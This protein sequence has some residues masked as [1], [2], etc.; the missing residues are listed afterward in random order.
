MPTWDNI[1]E[2]IQS[3]VSDIEKSLK[4]L[5]TATLSEVDKKA[6][7]K[8]IKERAETKKQEIEAKIKQLDWKQKERAETLLKTLND[9]IN[10]Q[11]SI[12]DSNADKSK[13]WTESKSWEAKSEKWTTTADKWAAEWNWTTDWEKKWFFWKIWDG[14]SNMWSDV[15]SRDKWKEQPWKNFLYFGWTLLTWYAVYRWAKSLRNRVTWKKK[16]DK[17]KDKESEDKTE[18]ESSSREDNT[19]EEKSFWDKPIWKFIKWAWAVLWVWT[20]VYYLAH[21]LYTKNWWMKDL[22]DWERGKKL[23]FDDALKY[24][25]WAVANQDNKEGMWYGLDLKYH[26][27]TSEI[28]AYGEKIKIDKDKR[29]IDWLNI[30]FKKYENMICTAIVI[31]YLKKTYSWKCANNDP[32]HFNGNWQWDI[33]VN[34]WWWEEALDWTWNQGRIL[35]V[36]AAWIAWIL[37]WIFGWPQA[38]L[39]VGGVWWVAWYAIGS[40]IDHNNIMNDVMPELDNEYW[41]KVLSW[42]L[43]NM[44]CREARNQTKE[45]IS[46]S[47]IKDKVR[48]FVRQIQKD[49]P[50]LPAIWWRMQFDAIPDSTDK[51]KYTIKA[52]GREIKAEVTWNWWSEKMRILSI[53]WWKPAINADTKEWNISSLK[54][55]L[56]EGLYM[57]ALTTQFVDKLHHKGVKYP[58]FDYTYKTSKVLSNPVK[59]L[60]G[61]ETTESRWI[62]FNDKERTINI[63]SSDFWSVD[64]LAYPREKLKKNMPTIFESDDLLNN[65]FIKFLNDWITDDQ[66][67]SIRKKR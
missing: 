22:W 42:Y 62:F 63:F 1:I 65:R 32:F 43:N 17:D 34:I 40:A 29:K 52:Y 60:V 58:Y 25:S 47:P 7:T 61:V 24:A 18:S 38:W 41:K 51:N 33:D 46:E 49:N 45:D 48:E 54:L 66:N 36:G 10:L 16:K 12:W 44:K 30:E 13:S 28:E 64:T 39:A 8:E 56:K 26:E 15:K 31:A 4:K 27:D 5:K 55:P 53:S 59:T 14:L 6:K 50:D 23:E 3:D 20:W 21:G 57:V 11:L 67:V 9:I 37:T 35:W 2:Q 19:K